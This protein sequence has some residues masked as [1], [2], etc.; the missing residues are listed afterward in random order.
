MATQSATKKETIDKTN[1]FIVGAVALTCFIV[2][3]SIVAGRALLIQ[4]A[5]QARVIAK[6]E[7]ARNTL[8]ENIKSVETLKTQ[9]QAFV[10]NP[11]NVIGGSSQGTGDRDGDNA[12][13]ILDALPSKYDF[14]ALATSFD[15]IMTNK[16]FEYRGIT[17]KDDE[18]NESKKGE[19]ITPTPTAITFGLSAEFTSVGKVNDM[20]SILENSIRP[21]KVKSIGIQ[22]GQ[23]SA[24]S[25]S[26]K[27]ET[28]YQASKKLGVTE[29]VVK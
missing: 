26:V 28:Y 12:K 24:V 4:R 14:P 8:E 19:S 9:Y 16:G 25:V 23:G 6:K 21:M 20:L 2:I 5:Y 15:K 7:L 18:L 13:I 3:F 22:A 11:V 29:E 27:G 17:G 1:S 10:T